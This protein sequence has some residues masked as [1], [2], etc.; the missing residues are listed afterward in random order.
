METPLDKLKKKKEL[1]LA[2]LKMIDERLKTIE[3]REAARERKRDTRRKVLLGAMVLEQM[4]K[5]ERF[6][7]TTLAKLDGFLV[8]KND[9]ALFGLE[10]K[11]DAAK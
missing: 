9:R 5:D 2:Q 11:T 8:R 6:N 7:R 4:K 10:P 3:T 1:K